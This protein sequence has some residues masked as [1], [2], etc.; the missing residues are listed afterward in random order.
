MKSQAYFPDKAQVQLNPKPEI[1]L[2]NCEILDKYQQPRFSLKNVK[3]PLSWSQLAVDIAASKYFRKGH[4]TSV[5]QLFDRVLGALKKQARIQWNLPSTNTNLLIDQI[6]ALLLN[7]MGLFNSP[8]WFNA[9]L[10]E[11]YKIKGNGHQWHWN[12]KSRKIELSKSS[13]IHPQISAC[14]IQRVDDS[15]ESIFDL[16][17]K[18]AMIFKYGSGSGVNFSRLRSKHELLEGGGTSSGLISFLEVLDKGAAAIKSGG[19]TRRAAKMVC[20]DIDHPEV[21]DFI[22][23]KSE[24]EKKAQAL[25]NQG[26]DSDFEGPAYKTVSGQNSNNS[27]RLSDAFMKAVSSNKK[28]TLKSRVDNKKILETSAQDLFKKLAQAAWFCADP[29]VQF[30]DTINRWHTCPKTDKIY[31]SNPCSEYMFLDDSACNL[32][33]LNLTK[34][35]IRSNEA[36]QLQFATE[37]FCQAV[38]LFITSMDLLVDYAGYPTA[39]IASTSHRYRPLGLGICGLGSML[40]QNAIPY[41]SEQARSWGALIAALM[42]SQAL[43]TSAELA[44]KYGAFQGYKINSKPYLSVIKKHFNAAKGIRRKFSLGSHQLEVFERIIENFQQVLVIGQ[45]YGFRNSQ[46]TAIAPTGTIGL[47]MDCDTT[48]IE[49][50]FSLI[51]YKNLAGGGKVKIASRSVQPALN[52]M[53]YSNDQ[54][55][56]ILKYLEQNGNLVACP[57]LESQHLSVFQCAQDL[58]PEAHLQMMAS[59]QPFISG[60]ISKTVNLPSHSTVE[61]IQN[62]YFKAWELGLK[63]VAI[64]RDNSKSH[65]PL[66]TKNSCPECGHETRL[67]GGCFRCVNC[68][69][70][71]ACVS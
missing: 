20:L 5:E 21:I 55:V 23:W 36:N 1:G 19:T 59:I 9:G 60:A 33:S 28:W 57:N 2:F 71:T 7:Q 10:F 69:F 49:P 25:I 51:K 15:L 47:V 31:A 17:K 34:F 8:V 24:E 27:V 3:A 18:E 46:L 26:Y 22:N 11:A 66:E 35:T 30:D 40:M 48:G 38:N 54:V 61:D 4:E 41:D 39:E 58:S 29:G 32:A 43:K 53:G 42:Q 6:R 64:Y 44:K 63:S 68:G 62:I 12:P 65:Q 45:K 52:K 70:T 37:D 13:Y 67:E 50:E 56:Q 14:F 16:L